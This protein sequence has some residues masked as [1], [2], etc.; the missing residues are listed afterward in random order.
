MQFIYVVFAYVPYNILL[1]HIQ[2]TGVF[3]KPF[4]Y[5]KVLK[6]IIVK[7]HVG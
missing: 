7:H 4:P 3:S 5:G 6:Y 2:I 1:E